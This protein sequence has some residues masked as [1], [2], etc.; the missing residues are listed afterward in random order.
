MAEAAN[1]KASEPDST[2]SQQA[3]PASQDHVTAAAIDRLTN[4]LIVMTVGGLVLAILIGVI[5][6]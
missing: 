5:A 6:N 3:A 2:Q 1:K 4:T